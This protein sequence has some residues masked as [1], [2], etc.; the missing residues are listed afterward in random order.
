MSDKTQAYKQAA[1]E[2]AVAFVESGMLLGLG[3]GST[4]AYAL[5]ALAAQLESGEL[6][7]I[8]AVP[9]SQA[10]AAA[11]ERLG[12]PL[13]T[14]DAHPN[15]DLTI[16]GADEVDPNLNLIKG[17]GG[18]LLREKIVAQASRRKI[19]IVDQS[20]LS[21]VLGTNYPLP[22]EVTP[23]GWTDQ[24]AFL[25]RLAKE[26]I[27]RAVSNDPILSD[28]GNYLLDCYFGPIENL[29]Q[30]A[31][32]LEGRAGIVEHGLFLN[33]ATDLI[34]AGPDGVDHRQANPPS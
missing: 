13:T 5:Q 18:A 11:A 22:V 31:Q 15:L 26:V 7:D 12:I 3:H 25:A 19:I 23:F 33:L 4:V 29:Y 20:K 34:V 24:R 30:L 2:A 28:G 14:L 10:T 32:L 1:A 8:S 16:D 17:G 6:K 27:L 21:P 9:C